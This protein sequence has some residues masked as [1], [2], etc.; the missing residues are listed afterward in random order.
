MRLR[1]ASGVLGLVA[2][3]GIA[4]PFAAAQDASWYIGANIGQSR[5]KIDDKGIANGLLGGGLTMTSIQDNDRDLGFKAFLG[6]Q[7]NRYFALEGG[8]VNLGGFD[9]KAETMPLGTLGGKIKIQGLDLDA[10]GIVPITEKFSLLGRVGMIYGEAKDSF[11]GTGAVAVYNNDPQKRAANIKFGAGLQ[12][13][14]TK[15]LAMRAEA[16][17]YRLNDAVGNKGDID[18]LSVGVVY[19]FG[20][21]KTAPQAE[22]RQAIVVGPSPVIV[23]AP[24]LVVVPVPVKTQQ[25]CTILDIQ[26]DIDRDEI[27]REDKE[28]LAVVGT[29]LTKYPD[30][31]AVIEG[32]SDNIGTAEHNMELSQRRAEGVVTYFV[33]NLHI[34]PSRLQAVGYGDSRP[35]GDNR[36]EEG[37]R[38]NRRIDA[39]IACAT[40]IEGLKVAPARITMAML[41]EFDQNKS[42]IKSQYREDLQKMAKFLVANPTVTATVEG[43][44]ANTTAE[45]AVVISQQRA[46]NVVDYLVD[47][48]GIA[49]S[50]LSAKGYG[51][52]RRFA[53]NTSEEGKQENRRV[54][55]IINYPKTQ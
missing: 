44:T 6:Y 36:T 24:V 42:E 23:E 3:A 46:Q 54:N 20:M 28:K 40:D 55:I 47:N 32:H 53:Y 26:F 43:H 10:L 22:E 25:Y 27:Q 14:F 15:S 45:L 50:R 2:A 21:R 37:K 52:S 16:E 9:F 1:I 33:E 18:L 12:Y 39:V 29:F 35:I 41:I 34:A 17:R 51:Q 11:S 31:T 49:R 4:S 8:Y 30:T 7:F 38:Q 48:F 13:D 19:R 5:S